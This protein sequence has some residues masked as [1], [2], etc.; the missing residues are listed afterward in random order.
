MNF[1]KFLS[2]VGCFSV[3]STATNA[4]NVW[5]EVSIAPDPINSGGVLVQQ[6]LHLQGTIEDRDTEKMKKAWVDAVQKREI[7]LSGSLYKSVVKHNVIYLNSPGGSVSAAFKIVG[8]L[9]RLEEVDATM[10]AVKSVC[11][12][13]CTIILFSAEARFARTCDIIGVHRASIGGKEEEDTFSAS[14]EI[15]DYLIKT[16]LPWEIVKKML[17]TK[18]SSVAWLTPID[19]KLAKIDILDA[20]PSSQKQ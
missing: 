12:S 17:A 15:A 16:G 4:A 14:T 5:G 6:I 7:L 19:M 13:A 20:C 3:L 10:V 8:F 1:L 2:I 9:K 11:A 18:A